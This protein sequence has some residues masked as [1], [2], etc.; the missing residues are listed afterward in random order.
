MQ[1]QINTDNKIERHEPLTKHV[2]SVVHAALSRFSERITRVE[3]HLSEIND[4]KSAEHGQ[5]CLMEVRIEGHQ[6]IAASDQAANL[7][8][9]IQGA[10]EKLKRLIDSTLGRINDGAKGGGVEIDAA[11]AGDEE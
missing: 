10:A 4:S 6:P 8:Q 9:A 3:V 11:A 2:E 1:I 7:H 5:R